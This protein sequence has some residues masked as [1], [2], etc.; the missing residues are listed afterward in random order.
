MARLT[1]KAFAARGFYVEVLTMIDDGLFS[2]PNVKIIKRPSPW[3]NLKSIF[4]ADYVICEGAI[5]VCAQ[6]EYGC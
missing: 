1:A 6:K 2:C 5:A 4:L 3:Q